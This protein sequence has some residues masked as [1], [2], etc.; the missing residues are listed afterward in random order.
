MTPREHALLLRLAAAEV[1]NEPQSIRVLRRILRDLGWTDAALDSGVGHVR[2]AVVG[3]G[4][5]QA[6]MFERAA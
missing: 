1:A 3:V 2:A 6:G 5:V 4:M